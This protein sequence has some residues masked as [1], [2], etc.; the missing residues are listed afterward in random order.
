MKKPQITSQEWRWAIGWS[1]TVVFLSC[2]PY[3]IAALTTPA[4]WQ[5]AGI[6]VNPYD[7][8][9]Y[10]AKIRQG[11]DGNWLFHLT[12]TPE[13]HEGAFIFTFYLALGH[14][15]ALLHLSPIL[16]FHL[17]RIVAGLGLLLMA[18][19][20]I[21]GITP[22]LSERRLA[23]V[24]LLTASGL[25]WLGA[26]FGAFPIDLWIPEAFVP[27]SLYTNP[28]FPLA[29]TL[30]LI[31]FQQAIQSQR[32]PV[33]NSQFFTSG[34]AAL[35]LALILPFALLAAE[36]VLVVFSSWLYLTSRRLPWPQ[37]WLTLSIGL[38]SAPVIIYDYW[39]SKTNPIL[40]GWS[41]QNI[42]SAPSVINLLL[43][44]GLVGLLAMGG[45][46]L[47]A[48]QAHDTSEAKLGEWLVFWWAIVGI[49]VVYLPFDLQ[50]RLII[51]LHIPLCILAAIGLS[52]ALAQSRLKLRQRRQLTTAV[53][54]ISAL[55]TLFVW[56]LPLLAA[57]QS[58]SESDTTALLFIRAEEAAAFTWLRENTEPA[59]IVLAS[60]RL[61]MFI[62]GQTGR[63]VFYGHPF[64]TIEAK[65]KEA[66]VKAFYQGQIETVSPAVDFIVYGPGEQSLGEPKH[67]A[68]WPVRFSSDNLLILAAS[69]GRD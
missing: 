48:R 37:I 39:V 14:L 1:I 29:M 27:Y 28:H 16:I 50:R 43:G 11:S 21:A 63:R 9:S 42:T 54:T 10:L 18:Y 57:R 44:Y 20:F 38:F 31:I 69:V 30:M 35:A 2:L 60:P 58:P 40:A 64:E 4:G 24:L 12:Y 55:G 32:P 13:P 6:L 68:D 22:Q 19:R 8:H 36:T 52:H 65:D 61:G 41:A 26:I 53:V 46:W 62:P 23:F 34:L 33:G 17:A 56:G 3:L 7:G 47:I 45:G 49:V 51:G 66:Q 67:L 5:F 25:G 59:D 15:A